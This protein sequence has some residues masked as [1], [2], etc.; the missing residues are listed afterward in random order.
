MKAT[1]KN[2]SPK[3]V[4][5]YDPAGPI[6][7]FQ[8]KRI[9]QNCNYQMDIKSEWVQWVTGDTNRT[10]LSSITQAEAVRIIKRQTGDTTEA[11]EKYS[12]N[13]GVFDKENGQHRYILSILR[14]ANI[15]V[16]SDKW[17]E[18]PD[19][20]GFFNRFLRSQRSPVK[21]PLKQMSPTEVSKI[22]TALEGVALW[23]NSI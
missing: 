1:K 20:S 9:L 21:K 8:K 3:A 13:W 6:T 23:K 4:P 11:V 17:G 18:I 10:S 14:Q 16:K 12:D 19:M 7:D 22:I 2:N 5:T 15:V